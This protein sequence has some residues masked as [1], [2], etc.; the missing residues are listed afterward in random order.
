[1]KSR[2]ASLL[3]LG[4]TLLCIIGGEH[5]VSGDE[6]MIDDARELPILQDDAATRSL[7][8]KSQSHSITGHIESAGGGARC[9][10]GTGEQAVQDAKHRLSAAQ[11]KY[12]IT[13][14]ITQKQKQVVSAY[15]EKAES[16]L[17]VHDKR[18]NSKNWDD[19]TSKL[20][21]LPEKVATETR[22][23]RVRERQESA[24]EEEVQDKRKALEEELAIQTAIAKKVAS[25]RK[26]IEHDQAL[27]QNVTAKGA[28]TEVETIRT[29][30][31]DNTMQIGTTAMQVRRDQLKGFQDSIISQARKVVDA[32]SQ[33]IK[34]IDTRI[35][36]LDEKRLLD[37][38]FSAP[39][40][41]GRAAAWQQ[42]ALKKPD[43]MK[44]RHMRTELEQ[45][46]FQGTVN[47]KQAQAVLNSLD[48]IDTATSD[49]SARL[50]F[51]KRE[52]LTN[53]T[54]SVNNVAK[55]FN[56]I[57]EE[58]A[59]TEWQA[60]QED[61]MAV[62]SRL[63]KNHANVSIAKEEAVL[64]DLNAL[65]EQQ[66]Q[67]KIK[68][69]TY[70]ARVLDTM[71][72]NLE[73]VFTPAQVS[74][75]TTLVDSQLKVKG[76]KAELTRLKQQMQNLLKSG[77]TTKEQVE[78]AQVIAQ[79]IQ[80][81]K[82]ER[83]AVTTAH[84]SSGDLQ[85]LKYRIYAI[86]M[87]RHKLQSEAISLGQQQ[88][89]TRNVDITNLPEQL[90]NP[91][92]IPLEHV[93][94][95][96]V[97]KFLAPQTNGL[98][99]LISSARDTLMDTQSESTR[100]LQQSLKEQ[101][102]LESGIAVDSL[103]N[104][105]C[106]LME[107][108]T[109][110]EVQWHIQQATSNI[111]QEITKLSNTAKRQMHDIVGWGEFHSGKNG[112]GTLVVQSRLSSIADSYISLMSVLKDY[113]SKKIVQT[114]QEQVG[115]T[116][117]REMVRRS[118][119]TAHR[120]KFREE[121]LLARLKSLAS[122]GPYT[123]A[124]QSIAKAK[125]LYDAARTAHKRADGRFRL[126][127]HQ[128]KIA[129][130]HQV[131]T[132]ASGMAL[133]A[134][135]QPLMKLIKEE[136]E[137]SALLTPRTTAHHQVLNKLTQLR[138]HMDAL[139]VMSQVK[140][141][142]EIQEFAKDLVTKLEYQTK[143][144]LRQL[145]RL[146][147]ETKNM[148]KKQK[149]L[150]TVLPSWATSGDAAG[151]AI[152]SGRLLQKTEESN[153]N[154]LSS[155]ERLV[156][157][158]VRQVHLAQERL[159][160][161]KSY[162]K[163]AQTVASRA[164]RNTGAAQEV[165][166]AFQ[167]DSDAKIED[168][169]QDVRKL[170]TLKV[171]EAHETA[172]QQIAMLKSA[173][174]YAEEWLSHSNRIPQKGGARFTGWL[175]KL[176]KKQANLD[177]ALAMT[178]QALKKAQGDL[179]TAEDAT[180]EKRKELRAL[181]GDLAN[182]WRR[183]Q[184]TKSD[185]NA[186]TDAE[187]RSQLDENAAELN[188]ANLKLSQKAHKRKAELQILS[189]KASRLQKKVTV[190]NTNVDRMTQESALMA[191]SNADSLAS[192]AH[193]L[194]QKLEKVLGQVDI[195]KQELDDLHETANEKEHALQNCLVNATNSCNVLEEEIALLERAKIPAAKAMLNQTDTTLKKLRDEYNSASE[196]A[197]RAAAEAE[198]AH[199]RTSADAVIAAAVA[200]KSVA[201]LHALKVAIDGHLQSED[202]MLLQAINASRAHLRASLQE[203]SS[204]R[205]AAQ[206]VSHLEKKI[207]SFNTQIGHAEEDLKTCQTKYTRK[208]CHPFF[209]QV[210]QLRD[211]SKDMVEA[212]SEAKS[213]L[214]LAKQMQK[215][216][217][218]KAGDTKALVKSLQKNVKE[219]RSKMA[220]ID[221]KLAS[222]QKNLA[223][224]E[225][226]KQS[227]ISAFR[228]ASYHA[229]HAQAAAD[230][231]MAGLNKTKAEMVAADACQTYNAALQGDLAGTKLA[232]LKGNCDLARQRMRTLSTIEQAKKGEEDA[233]EAEAAAVDNAVS[234]K[235]EEAI[236]RSKMAK[237]NE[238]IEHATT[239]LDEFMN[240]IVVEDTFEKIKLSP[241]QDRY[242]Q[243]LEKQVSTA[244]SEVEKKRTI[245]KLDEFMASVLKK[246]IQLPRMKMEQEQLEHAV[247]KAK[248]DASHA[249]KELLT[250]ENDVKPAEMKAEDFSFINSS[251]A[252]FSIDSDFLKQEEQLANVSALAMTAAKH[253]ADNAQKEANKAG[254]SCD[255][256][257]STLED[258][259]RGGVNN[260]CGKLE[261]QLAKCVADAERAQ[262]LATEAMEDAAKK[263]AA[264]VEAQETAESVKEEFSEQP[265]AA[266]VRALKSK[267]A[268]K[269]HEMWEELQHNVSN[270]WFEN[271]SEVDRKRYEDQVASSQKARAASKTITDITSDA[272]NKMSGIR[273]KL[274]SV[275]QKK[276][277]NLT[278]VEE[279]LES[280][281]DSLSKLG[282]E[283][284]KAETNV[285][286]AD[287][288][289]KMQELRVEAM[290]NQQQ[291]AA[292]EHAT[293]AGQH[294]IKKLK[295]DAAEVRRVA[296]EFPLAKKREALEQADVLE[297]YMAVVQQTLG[298]TKVHAQEKQEAASMVKRH[299]SLVQTAWRQALTS[300]KKY[301][302]QAV[303]LEQEITSH[304]H[305]KQTASEEKTSALKT[306]VQ[307][308][309]TKAKQAFKS[310]MDV[311]R[312][313]FLSNS[314]VKNEEISLPETPKNN[315]HELLAML[316]ERARICGAVKLHSLFDNE[317]THLNRIDKVMKL[318][319][320]EELTQKLLVQA[321]KM[322][323]SIA[324]TVTQL[325][326]AS[327]RARSLDISVPIESH[328]LAE[329]GK[330]VGVQH[331]IDGA[332][333]RLQL[334]SEKRMQMESGARGKTEEEANEKDKVAL[335][336]QNA[337]TCKGGTALCDLMA[338]E[339]EHA[340]RRWWMHHHLQQLRSSCEEQKTKANR[341]AQ[342]A[343]GAQ[344][345]VKALGEE[346]AQLEEKPTSSRGS[347]DTLRLQQI[348][349]EVDDAQKSMWRALKESA[350]YNTD[351]RQAAEALAN[352]EALQH[353]TSAAAMPLQ[354]K[355]FALYSKT[356]AGN[357]EDIDQLLREIK[358][359]HEVGDGEYR[360]LQEKTAAEA[361]QGKKDLPDLIKKLSAKEQMLHG[362]ADETTDATYRGVLMESARAVREHMHILQE[363]MSQKE[364]VVRLKRQQT[365]AKARQA[366]LYRKRKDLQAEVD[367]SS[368]AMESQLNSVH[369]VMVEKLRQPR[370]AKWEAL[371]IAG[372]GMRGLELISKSNSKR[373]AA[374]L[375]ASTLIQP[376]IKEIHHLYDRA[377]SSSSNSQQ[378]N[379]LLSESEA[380]WEKAEKTRQ[381][382]LD[383]ESV[384]AIM[385]RNLKEELQQEQT[386]K[387]QL[388]S[389]VDFFSKKIEQLRGVIAE[390]SK[391]SDKQAA[392]KL[393]QEL[394]KELLEDERQLVK[395]DDA[396][397]FAK[398]RANFTESTRLGPVST[399][400]KVREKTRSA[401]R[402]K[403]LEQLQA[404]HR[405]LMKQLRGL[406]TAASENDV[407]TLAGHIEG[408]M[409]SAIKEL[410]P[411]PPTQRSNLLSN[412]TLLPPT[413]VKGD[414]SPSAQTSLRKSPL[415]WEQ[416]LH[417]A[418]HEDV[419]SLNT[420]MKKQLN[421]AKHESN[422][423]GGISE[424]SN[425]DQ[426]EKKADKQFMQA[427][428]EES[429]ELDCDKYPLLCKVGKK[430]AMKKTNTTAPKPQPPRPDP[431][432]VT[433]KLINHQGQAIA[434]LQE[435]LALL[436]KAPTL[437]AATKKTQKL[438]IEE[439]AKQTSIMQV[440]QKYLK[441]LES[442]KEEL[443]AQNAMKHAKVFVDALRLKL[444]RLH[445]QDPP[446]TKTIRKTQKRLDEA[447]E[448]FDDMHS[449]YVAV[450]NGLRDSLKQTIEQTS[451]EISKLKQDQ[452]N[453]KGAEMATLRSQLKSKLEELKLQTD[454]MR[455]L[456]E[457][458]IAAGPEK[459]SSKQF[460]TP[461]QEE[462]SVM[463]KTQLT[464]MR[465]D[466]NNITNGVIVQR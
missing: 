257:K 47:W 126:A 404:T 381:S 320:Q 351:A 205:A 81:L 93:S 385:V 109:S 242:R 187:T 298:K 408:S 275:I 437:D 141:A 43:I 307:Q 401:I 131:L 314:G 388:E 232:V 79:S 235:Q 106:L 260:K 170:S 263:T 431:I 54:I 240:K 463:D 434:T 433:R 82:E 346:K 450:V 442:N 227:A 208:Q 52:A 340:E 252:E 406:V 363:Q 357:N 162:W 132:R 188:E 8:G 160:H 159:A 44:M 416:T 231:A 120:A 135:M 161:T 342:F 25:L 364:M 92:K 10:A 184:K 75:A 140:L 196:A 152:A 382:M 379:K 19:F 198:G 72:S 258:C 419:L 20:K 316:S 13:K 417:D 128:L 254:K 347:Q 289:T 154:V 218:D 271:F 425:V 55:D 215:Q 213:H 127:E 453:A 383:Q 229:A 390:Q 89:N 268:N 325:Q 373:S 108:E 136:E 424:V 278:Q 98:R 269:F 377:M 180:E 270:Y 70:Q 185:M 440:A 217:E 156:Y 396:L 221:A 216:A 142:A 11:Q 365:V 243:H 71:K 380:L 336:R 199:A 326:T 105:K 249:F 177:A 266:K 354:E 123:K 301:M 247:E 359:V 290:E 207:N 104:Q 14:R 306:Q 112:L 261:D 130:D 53:S 4:F 255:V 7:D 343:K 428:Q 344:A 91:R 267:F 85:D 63:F 398:G 202:K 203:E 178:S 175:D 328:K 454:E 402:N 37:Q 107:K 389:E 282:S 179:K 46:L 29:Q 84:A 59:R 410:V 299:V 403:Y 286:T 210:T 18:K 241:E 435:K 449:R 48:S 391:S 174:D 376:Q 223:L 331:V 1:M 165:L 33:A 233:L 292:A 274:G 139:W 443:D 24:A 124:D 36:E 58:I 102:E 219:T 172:L 22:W 40:D 367:S 372:D 456:D 60:V 285:E 350:K 61:K 116:Q 296:S 209:N 15:R 222:A 95:R 459:E 133:Q 355:L 360:S 332:N 253:A 3:L 465:N 300:A 333:R 305:G 387:E 246:N 45:H 49:L 225:V 457:G 41:E 317:L 129:E 393:T 83:A 26:S 194:Q 294:L 114:E 151:E 337:E 34:D 330:L 283:L 111:A 392:K 69:L 304:R 335:L 426:L 31:I 448:Y 214:S 445:K 352:A 276:Q 74:K 464:E 277:H 273:F 144:R 100:L 293:R 101:L 423:H 315:L 436:L 6:A 322:K 150:G 155:H 447:Q 119:H 384:D 272:M 206:Q 250:K 191:F 430:H 288:A 244:K 68:C 412:T 192:N 195:E 348:D 113:G 264:A 158:A 415:Q 153:K 371:A 339:Y 236:A 5:I 308:A 62:K 405:T 80:S 23:L 366:E 224:K 51:L 122:R 312:A 374:L 88:L 353:V 168:L 125:K 138:M 176:H 466:I 238:Q 38:A 245:S 137:K 118:A 460:Y 309:L 438:M 310:E 94:S 462:T 201:T 50:Q 409:D 319:R 429:S 148:I 77:I 349:A 256:L 21:T 86:H 64:E 345:K 358:K 65:T 66:R 386:V 395:K 145:Y 182:K 143:Q 211:T 204:A 234:K 421:K 441:K 2:Q 110:P 439:L 42:W 186:T 103:V 73:I 400:A 97:C 35:A 375:E 324:Q 411:T 183:F 370:A 166:K 461:T 356:G 291:A 226:A 413:P 394:E 318:D 251:V 121:S 197:N 96:E 368:S 193:T 27:L 117:A 334:I 313:G 452:P 78:R 297:G 169:K 341:A 422:E 163:L 90:R 259:Q 279:E 338:E 362:K 444:V 87:A 12:E 418:S 287:D 239:A 67:L 303:V 212:L 407:E 167:R 427:M 189:D 369:A 420:A 30:L 284:Q 147:A 248:I 228:K 171:A 32:S 361:Q 414:L 173:F 455:R 17:S 327:Q 302:M 190:L 311:Q 164:S 280:T 57:F 237:A 157:T 451:S 262:K 295:A 200:N 39:S 265:N 76:S 28:A 56:Q 321:T 230:H 378:K 458:L 446:V 146:K 9:I 329:E 220:D 397:Y 16:F 99:D 134:A 181:E 281:K 399:A 115:A 149:L 323:N 432:E